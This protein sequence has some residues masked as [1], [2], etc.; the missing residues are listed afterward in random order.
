MSEVRKQSR[1]GDAAEFGRVAVLLG[2]NSA[3]REVSLASGGAVLKALQSRAVDAH[4]VDPRDG[5]GEVLAGAY[6]RVF[7]ALH[8]RGGEDGTLQGALETAGVPYTGSGVLG[9]ALSM[10]KQ[11]TKLVWQASGVPTPAFRMMT[12]AEQATPIIEDLGLPLSVKPAHEGS[13]LGLTRVEH[14]Q[15]LVEA[16]RTAARLD[17]D[18]IVEPWVEGEEY[19]CSMLCGEMLPIIHVKPAHAYYDYDAKYADDA[20]TDYLI[21]CGLERDVERAL[22]HLCQRAFES[23]GV[24]G[25]GRVD[26]IMDIDGTPWFLDINTCPGMTGH[27][28]VPMAANA[29]GI[30]FAELCWRVLETSVR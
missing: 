10:D 21:P 22:Q 19:T 4:P 12:A 13:S 29:V 11:R 24:T 23:V 30:D 26:L 14:G 17:G 3:E 6:D 2:G 8:G 16:W 27:S 18:V 25:W 15:H 7:I 1:I 5:L 28:L 9:S 20:G